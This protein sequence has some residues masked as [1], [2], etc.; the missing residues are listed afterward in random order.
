[1]NYTIYDSVS[2][3]ILYT[4]S[5]TGNDIILNLVDKTYIEGSYNQDQ[6]YV[7]INTQTICNKPASPSMYHV[8][9]PGIKTWELDT[10]Q[11]T[12]SARQQRDRLLSEIDRVNPVWYAS[13]TA[14]QQEQLIAYRQQLL[15]VPQ[16]EG[17]PITIDW[18]I[19]PG[20]L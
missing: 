1:M 11:V 20:W 9:N 12:T 15:D 17:F 19:Q 2:G 18:P 14:E 6:Y 8:W 13:L 5:G 7:D 16:Q 10:A 4:I 3:E